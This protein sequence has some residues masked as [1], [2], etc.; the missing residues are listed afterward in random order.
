MTNFSGN[1]AKKVSNE[2]LINSIIDLYFQDLEFDE[3]LLKI[4]NICG[5]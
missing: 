4:V 2:N 1:K 3:K 5:K